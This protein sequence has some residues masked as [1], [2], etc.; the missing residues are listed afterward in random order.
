MLTAKNNFYFGKRVLVTGGAGFVGSRLVEK[1]VALGASVTVP[2]RHKTNALFLNNIQNRIE[3]TTVDLNDWPNVLK[4][5]KNKD[6]VMHLA[7]ITGGLHY[8]MKMAGAY[9]FRENIMPFMNTIEAS[10]LNNVERFLTVSSACVYPRYC[11]IPTPED[12]GFRDVPEPTS[13]G[14]GWAK[15]MQ[16]FLSSSYAKDY[17]MKIAIARPYNT[18][19][20][21]DNFDPKF[22]HA[23]PAIIKRVLDGESPLIVWGNGEQ[24]RS[25]I[26]VDD[27]ARGLLE[28]AEKYPVADPLNIGSPEEIKIKDLVKLIIELSG[29]KTK[30]V[31]DKTEPIG[32]PRRQCD[33]RKAKEKIGFEAKIGLEEGLKKTIQWYKKHYKK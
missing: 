4:I 25:F 29:K 8:N 26:Y 2:I 9:L 11:S 27:F 18:Y 16:E 13:M 33:N 31:F 23:I 5:T 7:A 10:R 20:P 15:R 6:I 30:V 14:Y 22:S 3:I 17:G 21:R 24:T 19:G 28:T 32:Q 12:E 1:L